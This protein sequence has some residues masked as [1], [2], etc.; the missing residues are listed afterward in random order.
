LLAGHPND[1]AGFLMKLLAFTDPLM[2]ES[3]RDGVSIVSFAVGI[4]SLV[5]TVVGLLYAIAQIRKTK[6]AANA[7]KEAADEALAESRRSYHRYAAGN[8]HRLINE[9]KIHVENKAWVLA[10]FRLNDLANQVAQLASEDPAW[11]Q[12]A[13]LLRGWETACHG[14]ARGLKKTFAVVKW[15]EFIRRLQAKID[16]WSGP[17]PAITQEASDDT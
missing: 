3:W 10:A 15:G 5:V 8:A 6:S 16:D 9:A 17:F 4:V 14:Q 12:L 11:R 13:D 1:H 2:A 7:A